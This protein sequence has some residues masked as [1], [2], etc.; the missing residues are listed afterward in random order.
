M[1]S[2]RPSIAPD[3]SLKV[4]AQQANQI[5][6][7]LGLLD[8]TYIPA[9]GKNSPNPVTSPNDYLWKLLHRVRYFGRDTFS[10]LLTKYLSPATGNSVLRRTF[11]I[12]KSEIKP[13]AVALHTQMYT[14]FAAGEVNSLRKLCTDGLYETFSSRIG[15]RA[16]GE[17]VQWELIK[18]NKRSKLISD[19]AA[20]LPVDGMMMRQAVVRICSRQKLTR[21]KRVQGKME[22]V[23]GTGKEKDVVE[24]VV[25]QRLWKNWQAGPWMVWGT[26]KEV[27]LDDVDE[28]KRRG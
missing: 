19:R 20:R 13:E 4:A 6:S 14:A 11:K 18:Y 9:T 27:T 16:K 8:Q 28:W 3:R 2:L 17:R 21:W 7:D 1:D 10:L 15:N 26:T 12:N 24:Y 23:E 25:V 22:L 5:P